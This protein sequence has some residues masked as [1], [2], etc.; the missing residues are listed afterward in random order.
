MNN[1]DHFLPQF[2]MRGWQIRTRSGFVWA[3]DRTTEELR[4]RSIKDACWT[5]GDAAQN[6]AWNGWL[7]TSAAPFIKDLRSRMNRRSIFALEP[8]ETDSRRHDAVW[9][10]LLTSRAR[11]PRLP[12]VSPTAKK[13]T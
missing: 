6:A 9:H 13:T 10:L 1:R 2:V 11:H 3:Y 12:F 7:E 8:L 4:E 5:E